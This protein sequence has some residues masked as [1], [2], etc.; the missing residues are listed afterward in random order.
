MN[1]K[2]I[3]MRFY[4]MKF[5]LTKVFLITGMLILS[6]CNS[7][8]GK[9]YGEKFEVSNPVD[10]EQVVQLLDGKD[11]V[12]VQV[13]GKI[14]D[15]CE[16]R[17]CW[18]H[19]KGSEIYINVVDEAFKIPTNLIGKTVVV[20]GEVFSIEAQRAQAIAEGEDPDDLDW[21]ED[22]SIEISGLK[23]E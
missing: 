3:Q 13:R 22:V 16:M 19:F 15:V 11:K 8:S 4:T 7:N 6:A 1:P 18:M 10:V 12:Q 20:N 5:S 2:T 9:F 14:E 21:I 17:G 23:V